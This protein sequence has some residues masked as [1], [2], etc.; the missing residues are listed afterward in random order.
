MRA[1]GVHYAELR[2]ESLLCWNF[3]I[4]YAASSVCSIDNLPQLSFLPFPFNRQQ[5]FKRYS[6]KERAMRGLEEAGKVLLQRHGLIKGGALSSPSGGAAGGD[7]EGAESGESLSAAAGKRLLV[8]VAMSGTLKPL[9]HRRSCID[10]V[11]LNRSVFI[12]S[13]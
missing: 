7:G 10:S 1:K 2:Y 8:K 6:L 12:P 9:M 13:P 3:A 11:I 5:T 4:T